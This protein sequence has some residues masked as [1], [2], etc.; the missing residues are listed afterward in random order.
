LAHGQAASFAAIARREG[1]AERHVR[2]LAQLAFVSPRIVAAILD[3]T[4]PERLTASA[5]ARALPW[6]WAEQEQGRPCA[7]ILASS[8]GSPD[9]GD[10][11]PA[12]ASGRGQNPRST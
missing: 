10:G 6:S 1:K 3:G 11:A 8:S 12:S 2:L 5:L 7:R 4:A 9:A